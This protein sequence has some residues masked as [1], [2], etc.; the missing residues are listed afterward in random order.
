MVVKMTLDEAVS[1]QGDPTRHRFCL[2]P[3]Y[4]WAVGE[5]GC[6][7]TAEAMLAEDEHVRCSAYW[8]H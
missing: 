5:Y 8:R 4:G 3:R 2:L 1:A 7:E 6:A